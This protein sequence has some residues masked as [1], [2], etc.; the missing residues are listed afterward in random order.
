MFAVQF[1]AVLTW[2]GVCCVVNIG[3]LLYNR[4]LITQ[5]CNR[6]HVHFVLSMYHVFWRVFYHCVNR[7]CIRRRQIV[8]SAL[9]SVASING[10]VLN[11]S[12]LF[13]LFHS[14]VPTRSIQWVASLI[15]LSHRFCV[16]TI[17]IFWCDIDKNRW[18]ADRLTTVQFVCLV[19][20]GKCWSLW[21]T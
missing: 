21:T 4:R 10:F 7:S 9:I 5:Y 18:W 13:N 14:L 12:Y 20:S 8:I 2:N 19:I 1:V 16:L 6:I 15:F 3:I 11:R 17:L